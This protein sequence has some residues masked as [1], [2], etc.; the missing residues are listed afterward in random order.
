MGSIT[1]LQERSEKWF[2]EDICISHMPILPPVLVG[3]GRVTEKTINNTPKSIKRRRGDRIGGILFACE[4]GYQKAQ[5]HQILIVKQ[6][7]S[8]C[9]FIKTNKKGE[10]TKL[11]FGSPRQA[12]ITNTQAQQRSVFNAPPCS[13]SSLS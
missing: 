7:W 8:R 6:T 12:I 9:R 13:P 11:Q 3:Q 2:L 1:S 10:S 5:H 4:E